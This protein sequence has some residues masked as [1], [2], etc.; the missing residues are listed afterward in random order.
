M[1]GR[2]KCTRGSGLSGAQ[3]NFFFFGDK[4]FQWEIFQVWNASRWMSLVI[5]IVH[6]ERGKTF[7]MYMMMMAHSPRSLNSHPSTHISTWFLAR[8][9][10]YFLLHYERTKKMHSKQKKY[11]MRLKR[12]LSCTHVQ[13]NSCDLC[14]LTCI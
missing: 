1:K 5:K 2:K 6:H 13:D 14:V 8:N 11:K 4:I 9:S 7:N 3:T 10:S 12:F